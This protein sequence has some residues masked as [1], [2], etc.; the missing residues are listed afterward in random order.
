MQVN[1]I[2]SLKSLVST[3]ICFTLVV[4]SSNPVMGIELLIVGFTDG[5]WFY[6]DRMCA[7]NTAMIGKVLIHLLHRNNPYITIAVGL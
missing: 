5:R 7:G 4:V 1:I 3:A 6:E 2:V